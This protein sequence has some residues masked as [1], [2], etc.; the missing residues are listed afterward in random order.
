[1]ACIQGGGHVALTV[2]LNSNVELRYL[3]HAL[4]LASIIALG[5]IGLGTALMY[6]QLSS[7]ATRYSQL[8]EAGTMCSRCCIALLSKESY[9]QMLKYSLQGNSGE[10]LNANLNANQNARP[11]PSSIHHEG[12]T[13]PG[14]QVARPNPGSVRKVLQQMAASSQETLSKQSETSEIWV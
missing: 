1:M 13:M 4:C 3:K 9:Q 5:T 2:C 14:K 6:R 11:N 12:H 7:E 8:T 10:N